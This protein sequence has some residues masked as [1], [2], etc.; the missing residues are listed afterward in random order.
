M[1]QQSAAKTRLLAGLMHLCLIL[2]D[3]GG[4]LPPCPA[5]TGGSYT[6]VP[7]L[8][9]LLCEFEI[10]QHVGSIEIQRRAVGAVGDRQH[11]IGITVVD[12]IEIDAFID[13]FDPDPER[14]PLPAKPEYVT[15]SNVEG[16]IKFQRSRLELVKANRRR[17]WPQQVQAPA[18]APIVA[19]PDGPVNGLLIWSCCAGRGID[20]DDARPH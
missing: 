2:H 13:R 12:R 6:M 17:I 18:P 16:L 14:L 3:G 11:A 15:P 7:P 8:P 9:S 20:S 10:R 1:P 5:A 19:D 4:K